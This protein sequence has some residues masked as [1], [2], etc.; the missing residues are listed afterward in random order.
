MKDW[1][2]IA[3]L[4]LRPNSEFSFLADDYSTITWHLLIGN[5]PTQ[6]EID[7]EISRLKKA[8]ADAAKAEAT[9]KTALLARLGITA[10][11][12]ALLVK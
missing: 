3:I 9:A 12:A 10:D 2:S 1:L 8:D 11:E 5:P 4:S 7:A 6:S